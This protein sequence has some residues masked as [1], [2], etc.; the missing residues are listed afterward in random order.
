MATCP[1]GALRRGRHSARIEGAQ[2]GGPRRLAGPDRV[3]CLAAT[4]CGMSDRL[5]LDRAERLH[6]SAISTGRVTVLSDGTPRRPLINVKDMA[7][8]IGWAAGREQDGEI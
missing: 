8:A 5:R 2:R 7:R 4:A 1:D 6:A 3:S